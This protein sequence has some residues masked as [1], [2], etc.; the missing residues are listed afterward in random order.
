M[1]EK[2]EPGHLEREAY[3]Y[4]RQSSPGQVKH[5]REG[6]ARQRGL[7]ARAQELGWPAH[8]VHV[9]DE[10]LGRSGRSA[11]DRGGF[12]GLLEEVYAGRVGIILWTEA[13]RPAR[14]NADWY[15][16]VNL[17]E[18][19]DVLLADAERVYDPRHRDDRVILGV[20]GTLAE[21]EVSLFRQRA[22]ESRLA[23]AHRGEL[24][25]TLASGYVRNAEGRLEKHPDRRV[26]QALEG[27]FEQ[28]RRLSSVR[29]LAGWFRERP[30]T[31]P[32]IRLVKGRE[33]IAWGIPNYQRL[34]DILT[35]PVYA[36]AYAYGRTRR[37]VEVGP[38]GDVRRRWAERVA[39]ADWTVLRREHH[40]GYIGWD[41]FEG[42]QAKIAANANMR[43]RMVK[44]AVQPGPALLAGLLR[45][46]RCGRK[47]QVRYSRGA[48]RYV[49]AGPED[50]RHR[51]GCF[52]FCAAGVDGRVSEAVLA[53]AEPAGVRAAERAQALWDQEHEGVREALRLELKQARYEAERAYRQ[54][55]QVEPEHRNVAATLER[56]W[57]ERLAAVAE[58]ESR[59]ARIPE[60]P[61]EGRPEEAEALRHLG[62]RL[63][64]VW[65][66]PQ[67]DP[68]LKKRIVRTLLE[69]VVV[70][71]G[72]EKDAIVL[73]LHWA[74]GAH[75]EL[76][77]PRRAAR[78]RVTPGDLIGVIRSLRAVVDDAEM[79]RLLNRAAIRTQQGQTWT[80]DRV[81]RFRHRH[82]LPAFDPR[83]KAANGW[84]LQGEAA[85]KLGI[86]AMSVH[87]L[88]QRGLL[89][90]EQPLRGLPCILRESDLA[91]A[92]VQ[93]A[94]EALK[95][96]KPSPLTD[97][98]NQKTL[99]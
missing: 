66:H 63:H 37:R 29:D 44:G 34:L 39:R 1:R 48:G 94:I 67:A 93:A 61:R 55:N 80:A 83:A 4:I 47:L 84:L 42:N 87:R 89:S 81:S 52:G 23:K 72:A 13:S 31:L 15:R 73:L 50:Q 68:K 51:S 62:E 11:A 96:R 92:P 65:H 2:I 5:H 79:A 24:Y 49:C 38:D 30:A 12:Q 21:Y 19:R 70:D 69:E 99:F 90:A 97:S 26:Q 20:Q 43:G 27:V 82:G 71:G 9:I 16:L 46:R 3:V 77:A 85:N 18:H 91:R 14:N 36:G 57:N 86:S 60:S 95:R 98:R 22:L 10:D 64:G 45:C 7:A 8:R 35:N 58:V 78:S 33:E 25:A 28:F 6:Q 40:P 41:E 56:I 75:T 53:V 54:F 59:L 74:G 17:C 88:I 32:V 76:S